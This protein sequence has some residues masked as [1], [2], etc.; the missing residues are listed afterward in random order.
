MSPQI[1]FVVFDVVNAEKFHVLFLE[2]SLAM[3][4]LLISDVIFCRWY[5]RGA[6]RERSVAI[7]PTEASQSDRLMNPF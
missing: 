7:L 6:N 5:L 1:F 2:R 3:M 4:V